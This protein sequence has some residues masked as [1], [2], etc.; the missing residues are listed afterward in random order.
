MRDMANSGQDYPSELSLQRATRGHIVIDNVSVRYGSFLAAD[1]VSLELAPGRFQCL[2]GPS[3]CGK[4][5]I[6][7]CVAGFEAAS[8][9]AVLLDGRSVAGPGPDR[10]VVFQQPCLFP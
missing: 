7:K 2:L 3:G 5:T 8:Q 6:L 1:R 9:G 10:G 4:S